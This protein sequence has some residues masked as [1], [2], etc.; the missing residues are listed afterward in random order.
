[1]SL[2][3]GTEAQITS[4]SSN[5]SAPEQ[6]E[7]IIVVSNNNN[8]NLGNQYPASTGGHVD[9]N[10]NNLNEPL[11]Y[12]VVA[13]NQQQ[14]MN[15]PISSGFIF[16]Q[17]EDTKNYEEDM[18]PWLRDPNAASNYQFMCSTEYIDELKQQGGCACCSGKKVAK[19]TD[20][21]QT[22]VYHKTNSKRLIIKRKQ[23]ES[24]LRK[25]KKNPCVMFALFCIIVAIVLF[26]A[27]GDR[28]VLY[29]VGAVLLILGLVL[30]F[31]GKGGSVQN[32]VFVMVTQSIPINSIFY[33]DRYVE[34]DVKND[35]CGC[36][37]QEEMIHYSTISIGYNRS[38]LS[39]KFN[40]TAN[41]K[42]FVTLKLVS[43]QAYNLHQYLNYV[44][45]G[46]H[47]YF[48][49]FMVEHNYNDD[50]HLPQQ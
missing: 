15:T 21:E 1:M 39:E 29:G 13:P 27:A 18:T 41:T 19:D 48:N 6:K 33:V 38:N 50:N 24:Q 12:T 35:Q 17:R 25:I 2:A 28:G 30:C 46:T 22:S 42:D 49:N 26:I 10:K 45:D 3:E 31:C 32:D 9:E 23:H 16:R 36:C 40:L 7:Q 4:A 11:I 14:P 37:Q 20:K 44:I 8:Q 5:V 47:P 34:Q 43:N